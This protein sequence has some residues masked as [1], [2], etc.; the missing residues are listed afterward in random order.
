MTS[1][2]EKLE[3]T[4]ERIEDTSRCFLLLE[5]CHDILEDDNKEQEE[6]IK[7]AMKSKNEKLLQICK[8]SFKFFNFMVYSQFKYQLI[9]DVD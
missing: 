9:T 8:A 7:I 3:D 6:F 5:S 2:K 1:F 4:R